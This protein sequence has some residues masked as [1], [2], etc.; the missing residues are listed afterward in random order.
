MSDAYCSAVMTGFLASHGKLGRQGGFAQ[1]PVA[2]KK[3]PAKQT[4]AYRI[5]S[6]IVTFLSF[7]HYRL[8]SVGQPITQALI[9]RVFFTNF[10]GIIF[11]VFLRFTLKISKLP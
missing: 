9:N 7:Y 3:Q 1:P 2:A 11:H 5:A 10:Y 8:M 6:C 4:T